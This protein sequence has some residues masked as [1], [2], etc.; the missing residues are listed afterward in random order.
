ML[1][2]NHEL[3]R[4]PGVA[5]STVSRILIVVVAMSFLVGTSV[6]HAMASDCDVAWDS[7]VSYIVERSARSVSVEAAL[8]VA[9][10][11]WG[12]NCGR[13][14]LSFP[15]V[16][17]AVAV[18]VGAPVDANIDVTAPSDTESSGSAG[19]TFETLDP[20]DLRSGV[21]VSYTMPED[22]NWVE[23]D[24][25]SATFPS[26]AIGQSGTAHVAVSSGSNDVVALS[27]EFATQPLLGSISVDLGKPDVD[28]YAAVWFGDYE[29]VDLGDEL[30]Y[31]VET[32]GSD[33]S[34]LVING[35]GESLKALEDR[36]GERPMAGRDL[37][38]VEVT[39]E[40]LAGY[41]GRYD[42]EF[43]VIEISD[44]LQQGTL[45]HE[46]AH[47]WFSG[48]VF[49]DAWMSEGLADYVSVRVEESMT[50]TDG[51]PPLEIL[52]PGFVAPL[53]EWDAIDLVDEA[54]EDYVDYGYAASAF[55]MSSVADEVGE[56]EFLNYLAATMKASRQSGVP[57]DSATFF[58]ALQ[59]SGDFGDDHGIVATYVFGDDTVPESSPTPGEQGMPLAP[60]S[61]DSDANVVAV[62]RGAGGANAPTS[63]IALTIAALAAV[64]TGLLVRSIRQSRR[65]RLPYANVANSDP[66]DYWD[67]YG[68]DSTPRR[69]RR[70][71]DDWLI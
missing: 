38:I 16:P 25:G 56:T 48:A 39:D 40:Q 17:N 2:S 30:V 8:S 29:R 37:A 63:A 44:S 65:Y 24:T 7:D 69:R 20:E 3:S 4:F 53:V 58:A 49:S 60:D 5:I 10:H 12:Q 66:D 33:P 9:D 67:D 41:A 54:S 31:F 28:I 21:S 36:F 15:I 35:A 46:L 13:V 22:G 32:S 34:E 51:V 26:W 11:E 19:I 64:A 14:W 45:I 57:V 59:S 6:S 27:S 50:D 18:T 70:S 42:G 55:V 68:F 23:F 61:D 1:M 71:E 62:G 47:A 43:E 52:R